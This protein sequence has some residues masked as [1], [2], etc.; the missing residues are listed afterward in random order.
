MNPISGYLLK[1]NFSASVTNP[2]AQ[3]LKIIVVIPCRAEP[4]LGNTILSLEHA[5]K[6]IENL[7]EIL[8]V[9][10]DHYLDNEDVLKLN[11]KTTEWLLTSPFR[12]PVH[13]IHLSKISGKNA[14]V[15]YARKKGMDEAINRFNSINRPDG[16]ICSMDAD[17]QVSGNYFTEVINA[18]ESRKVDCVVI[19]FEHVLDELSPDHRRAIVLYELHLRYYIEALKW[20]GFPH[21]YHTLGSAFAVTAEGYA[22]QGGMPN[23]QAGEDFYFVH[24]FSK[25]NRLA[26][27]NTTTVYPS[28]RISDR[29]PFGTGKAIGDMMQNDIEWGITY[30]FQAFKDLRSFLSELDRMI[31]SG[32]EDISFPD[33]IK[34]FLKEIDFNML[35]AELK[36]NTANNEN[37]KKRFFHKM[38]AFMMMKYIHY[39]RDHFYGHGNIIKSSADLL[40]LKFNQRPSTIHAEKLLQIYRNLQ[41]ESSS[42]T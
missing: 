4:D 21:A 20:A 34:A 33:S 19:H 2:P 27:L 26:E 31:R 35:L 25:L 28:S 41:K 36:S 32:L 29:V 15:G 22:V 40:E 9:I 30:P 7:I 6:G 17:T 42:I 16:I 8:I 23:R 14:G 3:G 5:A 13:F 37:F 24:K 18:F 39:A 12:L 38:N 10:N 1:Q 11:L